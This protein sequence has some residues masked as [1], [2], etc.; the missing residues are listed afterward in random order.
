MITYKYDEQPSGS[1]TPTYHCVSKYKDGVFEWSWSYATKDIAQKFIQEN[2]G[3]DLPY[4]G[5]KYRR[6]WE[7]KAE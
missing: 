7:S 5:G 4:P 6:S 1:Y 2:D 3:K